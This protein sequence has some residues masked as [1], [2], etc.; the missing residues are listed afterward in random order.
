[1]VAVVPTEEQPPLTTTDRYQATHVLTQ[2]AEDRHLSPGA[3]DVVDGRIV[4]VGPAAEAPA[5]DGEVR[6]HDLDGVLVPGFVNTH[7]HSAMTLL[8]GAGEGLPVGRW[9]TEVMWPREAALTDEDVRW[10]MTLGA[11]QLLVGGITTSVEM[12]FHP[13]AIAAASRAA[14]LRTIV[15]PPV[16]DR[17]PRPVRDV[18]GAARGRRRA[19]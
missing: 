8:R 13:A 14:G 10:G 9:L 3:V 11:A 15:T 1:M 19:G 6:T 17:R 18:A 12:Y 7:A 16:L 4:W 5:S 2:D